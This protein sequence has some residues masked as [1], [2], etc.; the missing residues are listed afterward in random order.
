M[1]GT[2]YLDAA[3]LTAAGS[4]VPAATAPRRPLFSLWTAFLPPRLLSLLPCRKES[5][6]EM[7]TPV[8]AGPAVRVQEAASACWADRGSV[9]AGC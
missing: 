7:L 5:P 3:L 9:P 1:F 6:G 4:T 2:M 8:V